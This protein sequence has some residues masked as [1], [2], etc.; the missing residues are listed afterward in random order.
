[1]VGFLECIVCR[2]CVLEQI[3]GAHM[4]VLIKVLDLLLFIYFDI[5]FMI[6]CD[7]HLWFVPSGPTPKLLTKL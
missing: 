6:V 1:M 4:A 7:I 5:D 2:H 3:N